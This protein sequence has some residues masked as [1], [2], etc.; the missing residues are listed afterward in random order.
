M[1]LCKGWGWEVGRRETT[2]VDLMMNHR[3]SEKREISE[4]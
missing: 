1:M 2:V 4:S 3:I